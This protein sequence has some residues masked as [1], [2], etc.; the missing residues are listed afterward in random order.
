M[1]K[2]VVKYGG[3][4]W[5]EYGK[6]Y[7]LEYG[8]EFFGEE[9]FIELCCVKVVFDLY[10]KMNLGKICILFDILFELVKVFDIKC[11]FYDC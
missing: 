1:V 10:N 11:G 8:F 2:F 5:G 3:L 9:L 7:C 6:G 4:M